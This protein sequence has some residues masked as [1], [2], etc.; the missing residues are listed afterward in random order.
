[1]RKR[2]D[3]EDASA[4]MD[5]LFPPDAVIEVRVPEARR[6]KTLSG[7]FNDRAKI[8]HELEL[9]SGE[10]EGV[11][12][13]LNPVDPQLLGRANNNLKAYARHTT[14]DKEIPWRINFLIDADPVR[15]TGI[16]STNAQLAESKKMMRAALRDLTS[17]GW[18]EPLRAM[19][20][21]GHHGVYAIDLPNDDKHRDLLRQVPRQPGGEVRHR[22][23]Q[24][25]HG[26]VQRQQNFQGVRHPGRKRRRD[27]GAPAPRVADLR[28]GAR[29]ENRPGGA[30]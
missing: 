4:A 27:G 14:A 26:G 23:V 29:E 30:A 13:T 9:A 7:Y 21:N 15:P 12:Y 25:R 8:L 5:W 1:M 10:Y 19:S 3:K 6:L 22:D 11:Y 24:G 20:G 2:F 18:P 28:A 16:S 17:A